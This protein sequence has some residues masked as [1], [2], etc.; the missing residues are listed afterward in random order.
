MTSPVKIHIRYPFLFLFSGLIL[1]FTPLTSCTPNTQTT[2]FPPLALSGPPPHLSAS[3]SPLAHSLHHHREATT[4]NWNQLAPLTYKT[5]HH[6][7][8]R[9][10]AKSMQ[11][12]YPD[13]I[14][15]F[16]K[17]LIY[18]KDGTAMSWRANISTRHFHI[19][20]SAGR[21]RME[22]FFLKMYGGTSK[23]VRDHFTT[24]R[25][26]P[27]SKNQKINFSNVNGAAKALQNV[28][29]TLDTLPHLHKYLTPIGG[30]FN[31]RKISGSDIM[32]SHAFGISIDINT[33]YA[34]YWRWSK[35]FK[36]GKPL[37]FRNRIPMEI[38]EVFESNGFVWG[39]RWPHYDTMHFEYRPE[40]KLY[41]EWFASSKYAP[42]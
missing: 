18:W 12:A 29:N 10:A 23:E 24:V 7:F 6:K 25:W 28:S 27:S 33:K 32:S 41:N 13:H 15:G 11:T 9:A 8:L 19:L 3:S 2:Q 16:G 22:R 37:K 26:L 40:V 35:E 36:E 5:I 31:W 1:L 4:E 39:G 14:A 42:R 38:V 17:D 21:I 20:M 30:T 34:D